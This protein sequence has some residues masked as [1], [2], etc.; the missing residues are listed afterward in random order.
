MAGSNI[1]QRL[2]QARKQGAAARINGASRDT[3]PFAGDDRFKKAWYR[4]YDS[5]EAPKEKEVTAS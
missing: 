1:N 5:A 2:R 3:M 4:G